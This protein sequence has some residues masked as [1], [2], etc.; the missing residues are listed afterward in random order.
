MFAHPSGSFTRDTYVVP[1]WVR[2]DN[3][4]VDIDPTLTTDGGR[5]VTKATEVGLSF[6]GGGRGP[7]VTIARDGRSV[8]W[9]WPDQLPKPRVEGNEVTYPDVLPGVD[10]RMRA[11]ASG[12]GQ[13]L[14]VKSAEAAANPTLKNI[15]FD[16]EAKGL[17]VSTDEHGNMRAVNPADQEVFTA[18]PPR[19]WDSSASK[20]PASTETQTKPTARFAAFAANKAEPAASAEDE[21]EGGDGAREAEMDVE[22][23]EDS[24]VLTPDQDILTGPKTT[25][26]VYLDPSVAGSREAWTIAY[27]K[28]P[29]SSYYNGKSWHNSDGSVGTSLARIGY[30]NM[31]NGTGRSFFR[32]DTDKLWSTNKVISKSTFRIKNSWS[33]SCNGRTSEVWLTS[34][35]SSSTT[36]NN[37]PTW[38]RKLAQSG[39]S[40]GYN[41]SCPAGNLAYDVTSATKEAAAGKWHDIT[42][43][44]RASN[45]SD[46]YG[47]KKFDIKS[48]VLTTDY[49]TVPNVPKGM[50]TSPGSGDDCG[51]A[52][53][54]GLIG[55][56]DV[57]LA[58]RVYDR[59]GGTVKAH[60]ILWPSVQGGVG[61][62]V[63]VKVSATSGTVAK[64]RISRSTLKGLLSKVGVQ[65]A[66]EFTW[67]VST[68]D[69]SLTSPWTE[70][71]HFV[72]DA[73]RPSNP[74]GVSSEQFPDGS[75]GW[76]VI[77]GRARSKGDFKFTSGGVSDV[78]KYEYWTDWES[79]RRTKSPSSAGGSVTVS[80]TP[81][82]A[83]P[84]KVYV[85]SYDKAGN[86][87][88]TAVYL[89][90][91][92][93]LK[94]K[95][96]PG[97]ING[98]G[99][100]DLWAV[101]KD[102]TLRRFY[103]AGDGTLTEAT[104][105]A[106]DYKFG[107]VPITHRDDWNNDGYTDL[108]ALRHD[109]GSNEER[110]WMYPN[111]GWGYACTNCSQM[112]R[113]ELTV[114]K[115]AN[116]HWKNGVKQ[117][118]AVGDV[119][120]PLDVDGDG[121]FDT[122]GYPDLLVN[123]GTY[124]WL[125]YGDED[126][127]LDGREPVLLAGPDDP[128]SSGSSRIK[129]VTLGAPGDWNG[130]GDADL[131]VRYDRTD[132]GGA[133]WVFDGSRDPVD[134]GLDIS[135]DH[136]T[137]VGPDDWNVDEVPQFVAAPD[138][139]N[140]GRFDLWLTTKGSGRIRFSADYTRSG[141][142]RRTTASDAFAGFETIG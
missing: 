131:L 24:L 18:S 121:A 93:G 25:Y 16:F 84:G 38:H 41:S 118:L 129:D 122:E 125:Y 124:I 23:S 55:N 68:E 74:P 51:V 128:I 46:V 69:G 86:S 141:E 110:L 1:Q 9:S 103:G 116:N 97:D 21:F 31:T 140:N 70:R 75:D 47:W 106:S 113:E 10:L 54:Y 53:P 139:N 120:G 29:N 82:S 7:L 44:M 112:D 35:I 138:A 13:L 48:A 12:F 73:T 85:K 126:Y 89:F 81:T 108:V 102:G 114:R 67:R 63:D 111:S 90:Y 42:L 142:T 61:N 5:L 15:V 91:A 3:K 87:S 133:I 101:D 71:C 100:A 117:I 95:D 43:G 123:D 65:G 19:M 26:P 40:K 88:D 80:L 77:T 14:V 59:D 2:K 132:I 4:L 92:N 104:S 98:D 134:G 20:G 115:Q 64:H 76:P 130:D 135:L 94:A 11:G 28:Y 137:K 83:G 96:K 27:K 33:W 66:G 8:S 79:G 78:A 57:T 109:S 119:D 36:W 49:N 58:A 6:S 34:K 99:N 22:V 127:Y 52:K 37:Q 60:F 107:G 136:R 50:Y 105:K 32:M 56:S 39:S 72:Y 30:E 45:E 62:T 17:K